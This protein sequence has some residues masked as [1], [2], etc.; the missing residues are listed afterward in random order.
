MTEIMCRYSNGG[1]FQ[2]TQKADVFILIEEDRLCP[3]CSQCSEMFE[4][5]YK[6]TILSNERLKSL[7]FGEGAVTHQKSYRVIQID[8]ENTQ[9]YLTQTQ[10]P[11]KIKKIRKK[12]HHI[13]D[14]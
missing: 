10:K 12:K 14:D 6:T 9:K 8:D 3:L 1:H 11:Q 2:C 5:A 7:P 4:A 13:Y